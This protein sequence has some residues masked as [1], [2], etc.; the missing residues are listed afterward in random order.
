MATQTPV[1]TAFE[2]WQDG[3]CNGLTDR[4][5]DDYDS[6]LK[7]AVTEFNQHLGA[8]S[9]F[10]QLDWRLIKAMLWTESGA[11]SPEWQSKS[12][13]IG[14][15]GD[16]GLAAFLSDREGGELIVPPNWR[17]RLTIGSVR[18]IPSHNIRAGIGYLL[19]RMANFDFQSVLP[20]D[21]RTILQVTIKPGDSLDKVARTQGSTLEIIKKLNPASS[22][23]RPGQILKFQKASMRRV[24]TGWRLINPD[25]IARRY[26]GGGD[27]NYAKKLEY[28]LGL[29]RQ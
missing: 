19:M 6:E 28:A 10:R 27:I 1:K 9:G 5:W 26:N 14:V 21:G 29:I 16:P 8:T 22:T 7:M 18:S 11:S 25:S 15:P 24:I 17:A 4:R 20:A 23:L 3:L 13:Q 12:M 2:K